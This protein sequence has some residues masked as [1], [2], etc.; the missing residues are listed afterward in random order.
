MQN[1]AQYDLDRKAA[2]ISALSSNN[3]A[4]YEYLIGEDWVLNQAFLN[5]LNLAILHWVKVLLRGQIK[6]DQKE[7]LFKRLKNIE[8]VQK[9][10][11]KGNYDESIYY[12]STLP[13]DSKDDEDKDKKKT[14]KQQ[15]GSKPL[16]VFDYLKS[17]SQKAKDLADEIKD[18]DDGIDIDELLFIGSNREKFNFNIFRTPLSFLSTVC[19]GEITFKEVEICQR[20]L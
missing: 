18:A 17:L 4:K 20:D 1:E 7:G 19:N 15:V 2:K 13:V 11:I 3:L 12:T 6:L 10:L 16:N 8:N 5:K 14:T 9:N